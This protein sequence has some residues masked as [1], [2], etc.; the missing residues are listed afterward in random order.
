MANNDTTNS[1][2]RAIETAHEKS[3]PNN[4]PGLAQRVRNATYTATTQ[5]NRA[6]SKLFAHKRVSFRLCPES[7]YER[8]KR[9]E[10]A[11]GILLTYDS[12]ADGNY[13][14]EADRKKAQMPILR[15]STKR[16]RVANGDTS[17]A[18]HITMLPFPQLS[19]KARQADTFEHFPTSLMSVG[20]T[21]DDGTISVFTKTG[22]SVH[23]EEDVLITC[24]GKPI[25]IGI[26]DEEGRYRIPLVQQRGQWQP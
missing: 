5:F 17:N 20:K 25:L 12:G 6:F 14:S 2:R 24:K 23:K 4:K 22:V 16:V 26:R 8:Q 18:K 9:G 15:T 7:K 21:S 19:A 11:N 3:Q 10:Q 13:I 1:K